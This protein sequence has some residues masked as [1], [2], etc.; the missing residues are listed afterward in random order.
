MKSLARCFWAV[1]VSVS[2]VACSPGS[3]ALLRDGNAAM[4]SLE[5]PTVD[6]ALVEKGI[7][8]L[9]AFAERY[10]KD[11]RADSAL[12]MLGSL[13]EV[14]GRNQ[15]ATDTF[16]M[17]VNT[18]PQSKFRAN[19]I[20]LAGHIFEEMGYYEKAKASLERLI[21]EYPGHEFV[22]NGSAQALIDHMGQPLEEWL[23]P[24]EGDSAGSADSSKA[25]KASV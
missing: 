7:T 1:G 18:Y 16:L 23:I 15:R 10:P 13:H 25:G 4:R 20:I 24:F 3:D 11:P 19:S 2:A 21:R 14:L 17:L 22:V 5:K 9:A 6:T 8:S 12:F